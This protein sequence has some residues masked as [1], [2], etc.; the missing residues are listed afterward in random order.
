MYSQNNEEQYIL[1]YFNKVEGKKF[2]EIGAYDACKF[3]NTRALFE[4]GWSGVQVE[5]NPI[6]MQRL[7][8]VYGNEPRIKLLEVAITEKDGVIKF[9]MPQGDAI[10]TTDISH[11]N[12]WEK[13]SNVLYSEI[14]VPTMSMQRFIDEHG[15]DTDFINI[16]VEGTNYA[17][18]QLLPNEFLGRL[19]M[20]CIEHDGW[21]VQIEEK[22]KTLGFK[23]LT[24]N[25]ENLIMA[26]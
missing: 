22:L 18:F 8:D 6:C 1:D 3:S 14:E 20:I 11:K 21:N 4:K 17:L 2:L 26:K 24:L 9:Y 10:G 16:D 5:P 19:K 7:K 13:G 23:T 15:A 25:P 12:K